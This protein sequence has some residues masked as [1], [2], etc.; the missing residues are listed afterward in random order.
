MRA[1]TAKRSRVYRTEWQ[2][3]WRAD[4]ENRA[5]EQAR[6]R[7]L[8]RRLRRDAR[9]YQQLSHGERAAR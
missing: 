8:Q 7:R 9:R 3:R 6:A 5:A 2:A 4:P 1:G